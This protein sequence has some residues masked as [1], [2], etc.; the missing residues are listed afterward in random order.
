MFKSLKLFYLFSFLL[1]SSLAYGQTGNIDSL[2][3]LLKTE[4]DDETR[5]EVWI[6]LGREY[7][8]INPNEARH[9]LSRAIHLAR[10]NQLPDLEMRTNKMLIPILYDFSPDSAKRLLQE[11]RSYAIKEKDTSSIIT[12]YN[13]E[14]ILAYREEQIE[15]ALKSY[16][17]AIELAERSDQSSPGLYTNLGILQVKIGIYKD[18]IANYFKALQ[19]FQDEKDQ[20]GLGVVY[21]NIGVAYYDQ[22]DYDKA[23]EYYQ[24]SFAAY[25]AT[26]DKI[27]TLGAQSNIATAYR[28]LGQN[29]SVL[30]TYFEVLRVSEEIGDQKSIV[31][32]KANIAYYYA[33]EKPIKKE[34]LEVLIDELSPFETVMQPIDTRLFH[35]SKVHLY[36]SNQQYRLAIL[37]LRKLRAMG[38][39]H[40]LEYAAIEDVKLLAELYGKVGNYQAAYN[41]Y[42]EYKVIS[43]SLVNQENLSELNLKEAE[44]SYNQEKKNR[45]ESYR[46]QQVLAEKNIRTRNLV[47]GGLVFA[48]LLAIGWGMT[49]YSASQQRKKYAQ[50]LEIE[51]VQRTEDIQRA[52]LRLKQ[53]NYELQTFSF[54][55]SHDI[56]EP[57]RGIGAHAGLIF[58]QLPTEL[59]PKLE[60]S[61]Q[62]I[63]NSTESLYNLVEDFTQY[64]SMSQKE[65][66]KIEEV[67]VNQLVATIIET[68]SEGLNQ[69][70]GKVQVS[71]LSKIKSS[72]SLLF[73]SLKNLIE[74]G[75]KFNQSSSPSVKISYYKTETHHEIQVK[76]NGIGID[77]QYQDEIFG[78]FKRLNPPDSYPGSG[79]GL[80]IVRL[81]VQKLEG[82][83][84]IESQEGE[85]ST[86]TISL[87]IIA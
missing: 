85:G 81:S 55:A 60:D 17:K 56:K 6:R 5:I 27:N 11:T 66:I 24:K 48:L 8:G 58:K 21:N 79:I 37:E 32:V 25:Q 36:E 51:V 19:I 54:I 45:E 41:T 13:Y 15:L 63:K 72:N 34:L 9:Y 1:L 78:M 46:L 71:N 70:R 52:N 76:D 75:L 4:I 80:A 68:F 30:K 7:R 47:A 50:Q 73:T 49:L 62:I 22:Q 82:D 29:E 14:G 26:N 33:L 12:L 86:F 10:E 3:Q 20:Y 67:D 44:A 57:I 83:V 64:T 39:P 23:L 87:P 77:F 74:N 40:E 84:L 16:D 59:K 53:L 2:Q 38:L 42:K 28:A 31:A 65:Q 69:Y 18:A 61:F 35:L 43:D